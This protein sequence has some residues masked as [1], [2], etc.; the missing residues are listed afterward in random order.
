MRITREKINNTQGNG[1]MDCNGTTLSQ[2]KEVNCIEKA[3]ILKSELRDVE[4]KSGSKQV[5]R[6]KDSK[7]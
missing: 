4:K 7:I 6:K 2:A 3:E 5:I 1:H